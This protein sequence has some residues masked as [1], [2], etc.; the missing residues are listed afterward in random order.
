MWI[1]YTW[2]ACYV[3]GA[4]VFPTAA[5][6]LGLGT[7]SVFARIGA[8][9]APNMVGSLPSSSHRIVDGLGLA[10]EVVLGE[11]WAPAPYVAVAVI[12][13]GSLATSAAFLPETRGVDLAEDQP[14]P[15]H[16]AHAKEERES[17]L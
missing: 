10:W 17:M 11:L 2:D 8:M 7:A 6:S 1:E 9:I 3:C 15:P 12:G 5:R 4:E 13:L 16:H 14:L